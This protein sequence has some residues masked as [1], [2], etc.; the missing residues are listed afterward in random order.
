MKKTVGGGKAN[1]QGTPQGGVISPVLANGYLPILDRIGPR[2]HRKG[3]WSAHLVRYA[4]DFVVMCRKEVEEPLKGV[5]HALERLDLRLN[6]AKTPIVDA[7]PASFNF[8][9][10]TIQMSRGARLESR[11]RMSDRRTNR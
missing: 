11:T 6:E 10:F 1:G 4:D 2:R 5:R 7:T 9:G 3:K 8:P